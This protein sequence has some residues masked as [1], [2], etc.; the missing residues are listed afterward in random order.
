MKTIAFLVPVA[1]SLLT[2]GCS[3]STP[4]SV[5][6]PNEIVAGE[7]VDAG[8]APSTDASPAAD[9]G[10]EGCS[11]YEE[12]TGILAGGTITPRGTPGPYTAGGVSPVLRF[13]VAYQGPRVQLTD[14]TNTEMRIRQSSP[15]QQATD[16]GYWWELRDAAENVLYTRT[17]DSPWGV[18][19]PPF[20]GGAGGFSWAT[21]PYCSE[22]IGTLDVPNT[23]EA[24][25]IV[26]FGSDHGTFNPSR[27]RA[28][29][30][31]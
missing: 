15:P 30:F 31:L 24:K 2:F 8:P 20:S 4:G 13:I 23:A 1:L 11:S 10:A 3:A 5:T 17:I 6:D 25:S 9:A 12:Q 18:E 28:R 14:V 7:A 16:S 21:S 22:E 29:F 27:E 19:V 26:F